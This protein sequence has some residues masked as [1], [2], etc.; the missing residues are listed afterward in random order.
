MV[1]T[2]RYSAM[3]ISVCLTTS[4]S[5]SGIYASENNRHMC[6]LL[7]TVFSKSQQGPWK[8]TVG[9]TVK[10]I[11]LHGLVGGGPTKNQ[12]LTEIR[13]PN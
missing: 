1:Q 12:R 10:R 2:H 3:V 8:G 9:S 11:G 5:Y 4:I 13:H 6:H 7:L